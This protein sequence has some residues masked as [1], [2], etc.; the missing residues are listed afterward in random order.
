MVPCR[1][2]TTLASGTGCPTTGG[3]TGTNQRDVT[4]Q[5]RV[6][7]SF[8]T[9][10]YGSAGLA[11][12][13]RALARNAALR[14]GYPCEC[15]HQGLAQTAQESICENLPFPSPCKFTKY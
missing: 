1:L 4:D 14:A 5:F 11:Y 7:F 6:T 12:K 13:V 15:E 10:G 3:A 9:V 8:V 2:T